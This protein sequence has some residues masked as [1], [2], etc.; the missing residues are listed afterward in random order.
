VRDFLENKNIPRQP[1]MMS[2]KLLMTIAVIFLGLAWNNKSLLATINTVFENPQTPELAQKD[3]FARLSVFQDTK[4]SLTVLRN[5]CGPRA[6]E[7]A[8]S[9]LKKSRNDPSREI[10]KGFQKDIGVLG[11][12]PAMMQDFIEELRPEGLKSEGYD[13]SKLTQEEFVN[14]LINSLNEK[15]VPIVLIKTDLSFH[16]IVVN[17]I[18]TENGLNFVE[19]VEDLYDPDTGKIVNTAYLRIPIEEFY[20]RANFDLPIIKSLIKPTTFTVSAD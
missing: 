3:D 14:F 20:K 9:L 10:L 11:A 2:R 1:K 7:M 18:G 17:A 5:N 13:T 8:L 16:W 6:I 19:F 12:S 4:K 15:K